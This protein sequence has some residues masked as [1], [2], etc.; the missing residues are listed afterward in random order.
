MKKLILLLTL[1]LAAAVDGQ[2]TTTFTVT[3]APR[4]LYDAVNRT[5]DTLLIKGSSIIGT[6]NSQIGYPVEIRAERL[7]NPQTTNTLY[8]V[9]LRTTVAEQTQ[10]DYIDYDELDSLIRSVQYI[11]QANSSITPMD[12]FEA[13]FRTRSGLSI[14]KVGRGNKVVIAMTSGCTNAPRNQMAPFVLD[15]LGRNLVSAKAKIDLVAASGQ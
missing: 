5:P 14:A 6:L 11:S 7:T 4:T 12:N 13:V 9:S 15:D 1:S 3:N 8:A 2:T 10:I